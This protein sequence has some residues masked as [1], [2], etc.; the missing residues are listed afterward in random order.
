MAPAGFGINRV[1]KRPCLVWESLQ[2]LPYEKRHHA[3]HVMAFLPLSSMERGQCPAKR[4][5]VAYGDSRREALEAGPGGEVKP[6]A[7]RDTALPCPKLI[8]RMGRSKTYAAPLFILIIVILLASLLMTTQAS[9]QGPSTPIPVN[10][11]TATASPEPPT[12]VPTRTP[13][14]LGPASAE[15]LS[16]A[17]NVRAQPDI[18]GERLGQISPGQTY[19]IRGRFFEWLQILFPDSPSGIGWVH[20]SVVQILGD[21]SLIPDLTVEQLPTEAPTIVTGRETAAVIT[22]TPGGILTLTAQ[23]FITPEGV[24][25]VGPQ[26]GDGPQPSDPI[27][28]TYT[29]PAETATPIDLREISGQPTVAGEE[30]EG[31]PPIVPIAA[32]IALGGLGL[33]ISIVRRR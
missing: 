28:P 21:E 7:C 24:F 5:A 3:L 20:Q 9:A 19:P 2:T 11:P 6:L 25:T 10:P 13:T 18:T 16:D 27:L 22:Q 26:A 29:F 15:A 12:D 14:S 31:I 1:G 8:F 23:T 30:A 33:L 4:A 32:L 17:T